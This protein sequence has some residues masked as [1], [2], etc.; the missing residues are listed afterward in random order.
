MLSIRSIRLANFGPFKGE[1]RIEF[2]AAS[3]V[4]IIY[5]ENM[6]G[7]TTLLNAIRYALFGKVIT[8]GASQMALHQIGN[9][10]A[11]KEKGIYGFKVVLEFEHE[12]ASYELTREHRPRAGIAVPQSDIDYQQDCFLRKNGDVLSPD[13]RDAAIARI[14]PETVSRFFLFDGELLQQYEE[15]LHNESDMGRSIKEAIER[16]LGVPVLTNGRLDLTELAKDAQKREAKAAQKNQKTQTLGNQHEALLVQR[17]GQQQEVDRLKGEMESLRLNKAALE[18][19]MR[20]TQRTKGLLD[21]RQRLEDAITVAEAKLREKEDRRKELL[22]V[23]WKGLLTGRIAQIRVALEQD[24]RALRDRYQRSVISADVIGKLREALKAGECSTCGNDLSAAASERLAK[25]IADG[26]TNEDHVL[27]ETGI[28]ELDRRI[29]AL[30][31]SEAGSGIEVLQEIQNAIDD[32]RI[33]KASAEDSLADIREQ[34][35]DLDET[36]VRRLYS[37]FEKTVSE[38]T[39]L[40]LGVKKQEE[41]LRTANDNI[42]KV[43]AEMAKF[44]DIDLGTERARKEMCESLRTLFAAAVDAYRERL[45]ARVERDATS[46]F[47]KLTSEPEYTALSINDS[48]GLTIVH[49]DGSQIPVRSAGAEHIVALSLMGA[50]QRN[51][52]LSGPIVMDSPFGRLDN[53]HTTKVVQALSSMADQVMLLVYESELNPTQAR[54]QLQ[55]SLRKEYRI[56]RLTARHSEL[57]SIV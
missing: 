7:K 2:P 55:G 1:Q 28:Q 21:D 11:A 45:R 36:E 56:A 8:R 50:L 42:S 39:I 30:K 46:L 24:L 12:A 18:D 32:L 44:S 15:L 49:E 19:Q 52:P 16:I 20:K 17:D 47:V 33:E 23:A 9:W 37:D 54:N 41:A 10:E 43:E 22:T 6:R 57:Q 29:T 51:A 38:L 31:Q 40:Q 25:L 34:T 5:G 53:V 48:Y 14:M 27:L 26:E 3:G 35:K 4:S 13:A